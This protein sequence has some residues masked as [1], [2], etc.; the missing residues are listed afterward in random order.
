M[1]GYQARHYRPRPIPY[2]RHRDQ[3][4]HQDGRHAP[5]HHQGAARHQQVQPSYPV[6]DLPCQICSYKQPYPAPRRPI[7]HNHYSS[8]SLRQTTGTEESGEE[9]PCQ[10]CKCSHTPYPDNR[11]KLVLSD[12]TLH[13]FFAPPNH[14]GKQYVGDMIH[15]DYLTIPEGCLEDLVHAFRLEYELLNH[16]K[17]L[18][19]LVVAGYNDLLQNKSRHF[20]MEGY[21]HLAQLVYN[22]GKDRHPG[23]TNS[24]A[25]ASLLYPPRLSWFPD[26]GATPRYLTNNLE[27][28]DWLNHEIHNLNL[29]NSVSDFPRFHTYGVRTDNTCRYDRY[30]YL[31]QTH[32]KTHRWEHWVEQL[33]TNKLHLKPERI[34]IM[35]TAINN[36]FALNTN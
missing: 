15:V 35:A 28:I 5:Q 33:K 22:L 36:Y 1:N 27:K 6:P 7:Y 23:A 14:T 19:V 32:T 12:Y 3:A 24:F 2:G 4:R 9:Y 13:H 30:G 10:S 34:F 11:I 16:V 25:V 8:L 20:I 26:N 21:K 17:P 29:S 31:H 18:D